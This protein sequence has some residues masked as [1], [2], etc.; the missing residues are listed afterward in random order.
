MERFLSKT[1]GA[2]RIS[3]A[4]ALAALMMLGPQSLAQAGT[5]VVSV[6]IGKAGFLIGLGNGRGA[7]N[8]QGK[9]YRLRI[10]RI[11]VGTIGVARA[12]LVG[13]AYN[14]RTA[15]DITG[16]YSAVTAGIAF[17]AGT[18]AARLRNSRGVVLELRGLQ[19]GL[20]LTAALSGMSISLR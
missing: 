12:H 18:K 14:L 3:S 4:A 20:D 2:S 16:S 15:T 19:T 17:G 9:N 1:I 7:L 8:Y 10:S 5:G 13:R 11:S 6:T